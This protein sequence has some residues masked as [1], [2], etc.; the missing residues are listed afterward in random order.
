MLRTVLCATAA[1]LLTASGAS[2]QSGVTGAE[3]TP[4][5]AGAATLQQDKIPAGDAE[6]TAAPSSPEQQLS[7]GKS[8]LQQ[9][10]MRLQRAKDTAGLAD[11]LP[12]E[13][14]ERAREIANAGI[15][16]VDGALQEL[17]QAGKTDEVQQ[18]IRNAALQLQSTQTAVAELEPAAPDAAIQ[19]LKDLDRAA[20]EVQET[21]QLAERPE[22]G[23]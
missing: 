7:L 2:A 14:I 4:D 20:G 8:Q 16:Q 21:S 15:T 13:E 17:L 6:Q 3:Q 5:S 23:R 10:A 11:D 12:Q 19:A 22:T 1:L 18:A 9:A